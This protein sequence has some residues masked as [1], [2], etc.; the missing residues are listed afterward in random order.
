MGGLEDEMKLFKR[1]T[2][3]QRV[4]TREE[5]ERAVDELGEPGGGRPEAEQSRQ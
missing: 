5:Y 1:M 2:T 4:P 3:E